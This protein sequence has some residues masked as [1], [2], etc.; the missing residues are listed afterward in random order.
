MK[1]LSLLAFV[2]LAA[3]SLPNDS[4]SNVAGEVITN[5]FKN[6]FEPSEP[7]PFSGEQSENRIAT[8]SSN[9][10]IGYP[11]HYCPVGGDCTYIKVLKSEIVGSGEG[12]LWE[13]KANFGHDYANDVQQYDV[14]AYCSTQY[15]TLM[16]TNAD[17]DAEI[18]IFPIINDNDHDN[19]YQQLWSL[20]CYDSIDWKTQIRK[21][22]FSITPF[23]V[24]LI[25]KPADILSL[26]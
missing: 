14:Y 6:D 5:S 17:S 11:I 4:D 22:G 3:C 15:P 2:L 8:A 12:F 25:K 9:R 1:K 19:E 24:S 21:G 7:L 26:R 13:A 20:I 23:N 10:F 16:I 18:E